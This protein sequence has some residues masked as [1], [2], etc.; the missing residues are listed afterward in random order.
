MVSILL[1][2]PTFVLNLAYPIVWNVSEQ[3][4]NAQICLERNGVAIHRRAESVNKFVNGQLGVLTRLE[5]FNG[6]KVR[7]AEIETV[8][9]Q[10]RL[11]ALHISFSV[12]LQLHFYYVCDMIQVWSTVELLWLFL[13]LT[14]SLLNTPISYVIY[15]IISTISWSLM[16]RIKTC[17]ALSSVCSDIL[18]HTLK[19]KVKCY[20]Q[21]YQ[22]NTFYFVELFK[23]PSY[24]KGTYF[25]I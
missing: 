7:F 10:V 1:W 15:I 13:V 16:P 19:W 20:V 4:I 12:L 24:L 6:L 18:V 14:A 23:V 25:S 2:N 17:C 22:I 5:R 21:N 11:I 9:P 3:E 8:Q